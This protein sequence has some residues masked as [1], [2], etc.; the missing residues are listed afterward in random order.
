MQQVD[1][2][3]LPPCSLSIHC[4][5]LL[6][7]LD[8]P[9]ITQESKQVSFTEDIQDERLLDQLRIHLLDCPTCAAVLDQARCV[10]TQQRALLRE[11]LL[12]SE[13][14][15]TPTTSQIF[16]AIRQGEEN[17]S[18]RG[19][20]DKRVGY[21]LQEIGITPGSPKL[22]GNHH[23]VELRS[24][25]HS[26]GWLYSALALVTAATVILFAIGVLNHFSSRQVHKGPIVDS[27]GWNSVVIGLTLAAPR[28]A[29]LMG[30]YNYNPVSGKHVELV[31]SSQVS[32]DVQL[33]GVS[34]DGHNL[35]YQATTGGHILYSTL[36]S[37]KGVGSFYAL[38]AG[39]AGNAIWM[40]SDHALIA[41]ENSGVELVDIH[42]SASTK[43]FPALKVGRLVFY[44]APY[45][46]FIGASAST[47]SV[48]YRIDV[49]ASDSVPQAISI[50]IAPTGARFKLSP[51]GSTIYYANSKGNG[52]PGIHAVRSDGTHPSEVLSKDVTTVG[53]AE[54][55]GF[56]ADNSL[57]AIRFSDGKFQVIKYA[58]SDRQFRVV[59]DDAAPDAMSLCNP[60]VVVL[61]CDSNVAFAPSGHG[62]VVNAFCADGHQRIWFDNLTTGR[63]SLLLKL[64][65]N[66]RVQL[67]GWDRIPV[68]A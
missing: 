27:D 38:N 37:G 11:L 24:I 61:M 18:R 3:S 65:G 53:Y 14:A 22:N 35:L 39:N 67:A 29:K 26:Y 52:G 30:I 64:D 51:D 32:A 8:E 54:P 15:V 56:A 36:M 4:L 21:Y 19:S 23:G 1:L 9:G 7:D 66:T 28:V 48:L 2:R 33:D 13:A 60:G 34:P 5:R 57:E 31:S 46:Y 55:I 6:D 45:M 20:R 16:A 58:A 40:D 62:L 42:T 41:M 49:K 44:H 63:H 10:R 68:A 47:K 25:K 17:G 50:S 12:E 59:V 43:L